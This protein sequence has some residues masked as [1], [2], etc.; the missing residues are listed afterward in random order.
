MTR[1]QI[2]AF[3]VLLVIVFVPWML[4]NIGKTGVNEFR[5]LCWHT[6]WSE[7]R[8]CWE[9]WISAFRKGKP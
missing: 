2:F 8:M 7:P 3:R 4:W 1:H 9:D 5:G 6:F